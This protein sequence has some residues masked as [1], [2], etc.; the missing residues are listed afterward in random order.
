M[1]RVGI[2]TFLIFCASATGLWAKPS[3]PQTPIMPL[4]EIKPGMTATWRTVVAGNEIEEYNMKI[5]GVSQNFAGPDEPVIIAEALDDS[6]ILSGPV[7]GMSGSPCYI[8]G[9]LIGAYAYGY[10]WPKEQALIGITPIQNMLRVFEKGRPEDLA[11][12]GSVPA[13]SSGAM[14]ID[15]LPRPSLRLKQNAELANFGATTNADNATFSD[16]KPAPTPLIAGGI[17]AQALEPFRAYAQAMNLDL[18]SAPAGSAPDLTASDIQPGSPVAGVLL[19]GDFSIV[20]TGTCTW[21]EGN[22]FL[23]FGHPFLMGGPTNIPVAPAEILT[24]VRSVPRSFKLS[25]AGPI[26]G[27]IYQDRLTAIAGE[28]GLTSP[29]TDYAINITD[30]LGGEHHYSGTLFQN[31]SMSP[32]IAVLGLYSAVNS[33]LESQQDLT[34]QLTMTADYEGYEP[35]VWSRVSSSSI[36]SSLFEAWDMLGMLAENPFEPT[37]L[38][39]LKFDVKL[40][41]PRESTIMDRLQILSGQAKA[42]EPVELAIRL[43]SYRDETSRE[44]VKAPI[45]TGAAGETLSLFVGDAAAADRIDDGYSPTVSTFGEILDYFRARRDNQR[46]YVKLMR[47]AHGYR[48][49]GQN[50]EDLPPS[51]RSLLSSSKTVEPIASTREITL[52]ETS[53]ETPGSFSGSHRFSLPVQN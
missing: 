27:T 31:D 42:G 51:A 9:K 30:P 53:I 21:R 35:L 28:V 10:L 3:A 1:K 14:H 2:I 45:P 38:K 49:H 15:E 52:W 23:A 46:V 20:A 40:S 16:L 43:K 48:A 32:Y 17:S 50:L 41:T 6:Q 33:T 44:L 39:S 25:N 36:L 34:Y 19:N 7:G 13:S 24:V 47:S 29:M 5:L 22:D 12:S 26:V 18:M 11:S 37:N 4:S 8:D